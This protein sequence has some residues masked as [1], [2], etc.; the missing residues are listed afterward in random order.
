MSPRIA[1]YAFLGSLY[2]LGKLVLIL[3]LVGAAGWGVWL[4]IQRAF[5]Q[6]PDFALRKIEINPN[7]VIDE[8]GV[9][10]ISGISLTN[11]PSLFDIDTKTLAEKLTAR[12]EIS[13]A[14]VERN[15]PGTLAIHI[16]P[17]EP[18]AWVAPLGTPTTTARRT[19]A[20]LVDAERIAYQCPSLQVSAAANLPVILLAK[21]HTDTLLPGQEIHDPALKHCFHLLDSIEAKD[22]AALNWIESIRQLNDWSL[23]LT[24][25]QGTRATFSLGDHERQIETLRRALEHAANKG[26]L[27]STI[28]LIPKHNIPITI[29]GDAPPVEDLI[30]A[31]S[32]QQ[33]ETQHDRDLD[34]L[35]NRN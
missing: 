5:Y 13:A 22:P 26:Y 11:V 10:N 33:S 15:L 19:G 8:I 18:R 23:V 32:I 14:T 24:T 1:W 31:A 25:R 20:M 6:N 21:A 16:T 30:P 7:P 29:S 12:P 34:N 27:I 17:R 35:L 3:S 9:A 28:N 2:R 4:A